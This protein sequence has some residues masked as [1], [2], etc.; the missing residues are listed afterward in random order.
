MSRYDTSYL[1]GGG[2]QIGTL[3]PAPGSM[4]TTKQNASWK[5]E[6]LAAPARRGFDWI[7]HSLWMASDGSKAACQVNVPSTVLFHAG[8]PKRWIETDDNGRA[9]RRLFPSPPKRTGGGKSGV[10]GGWETPPR[11]FLGHPS[12]V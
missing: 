4:P 3:P 12:A 1:T 10:W 11:P 9:V 6:P 2:S 7:Y 8:E 5:Q